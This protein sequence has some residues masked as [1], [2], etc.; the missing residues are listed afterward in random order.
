MTTLFLMR[1]DIFTDSSSWEFLILNKW[2]SKGILIW[3]L[4]D[5]VLAA[6]G[7]MGVAALTT[8]P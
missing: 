5:F 1:I 2:L 7:N 6:R 4:N 3:E 8:R